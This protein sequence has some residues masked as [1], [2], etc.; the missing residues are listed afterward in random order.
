M[1]LELRDSKMKYLARAVE[2]MFEWTIRLYDYIINGLVY[3]LLETMKE[4]THHYPVLVGLLNSM[5]PELQGFSTKT[6]VL[7]V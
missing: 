2:K 4:E 3:F 5:L 6:R 7:P 1:S